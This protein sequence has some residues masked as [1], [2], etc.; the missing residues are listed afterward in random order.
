MELSAAPAILS[1]I[2]LV[3]IAFTLY[4]FASFIYPYLRPSS[5]KKYL[6]DGSY[7][8]VTGATDGIGKA[9]AI[10][11]AARG[12]NIILH[13]RNMDKLSMVSN[14]IRAVHP[15]REVVS[16]VQD[17]SKDPRL[18]I[19]TIRSLP[20]SVLVNNVGVGPV[21]EFD[22]FSSEQIDQTVNLNALF[23]T[24][25][26]HS[27]LPLFKR[28]ALILNVSSYV[29]IFPPP[30]LAVYSGTKAYNTAFSNSLSRE[31][32][33]V[34]TIAL[35]TGSVHTAGNQKP[36][37]F[38]RPDGRVYAKHILSIVGC[39]RKSIMPYWPHAVQ[40]FILSLLPG[41]LIERAIKSAM[42]REIK[43]V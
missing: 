26:T 25:L 12:F 18:N 29:G 11:L 3:A 2:G 15:G 19:S 4:K 6:G 43:G 22:R 1:V 5:I 23:P 27:L 39:G 41:W 24:H 17:G 37:T 31:I 13:G 36:V 8:L 14:E 38:L 20:I 21:K 30:Y 28:P 32:P 34:E 42:E 10:E 16:L 9:L 33:S 7:A 35:I 40:V